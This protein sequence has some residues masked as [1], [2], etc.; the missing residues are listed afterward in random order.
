[1][2][3][4]NKVQI[5]HKPNWAPATNTIMGD[6]VGQEGYITEYGTFEL[7]GK[8]QRKED[9]SKNDYATDVRGPLYMLSAESG[10]GFA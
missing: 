4:E 1:M 9:L 6:I 7:L 8:V 3:K 10:T 5:L 2:A